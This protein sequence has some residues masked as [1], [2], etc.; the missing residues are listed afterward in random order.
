MSDPTPKDMADFRKA[1][2]Q[3]EW[4]KLCANKEFLDIFTLD[5][6]KADEIARK[7]LGE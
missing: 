4:D 2:T 3:I 1:Y 6:S 7:V 5:L